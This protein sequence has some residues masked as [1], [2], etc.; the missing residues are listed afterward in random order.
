MAIDHSPR[1]APA[2]AD[3]QVRRSTWRVVSWRLIGLSLIAG[4]IAIAWLLPLL[5]VVVSSFKGQF[6]I[7]G[8]SARFLPKAVNIVVASLNSLLVAL[9][10]T[11]GALFTSSL[12]GYAFARLS[13]PV[14]GPLFVALLATMMIPFEVILVPLF[15]QFDRFGLLNSYAALILPHVVSVFGIFLMRQFMQGIPRDLED[16]ARVD[17]ASV[18]Q[19]Y[20]QVVLPLTRPALATLGVFVFLGSWNDFLWPLIVVSSPDRQ[21]LPL[22]LITFRGAYGGMNY[23]TV[24][25]SVVLAIAPPLIFFLFAQRLV[26]QSISRSGL[27]G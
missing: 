16:A 10:S 23:G 20:Y 27:K 12:A 22:A 17:G 3:E 18:W 9:L 6:E 15:I 7:I 4:A 25:A 5:W 8:P 13:F 26:V 19:V 14:K 21:T 24:L 11:A 1:L 2:R